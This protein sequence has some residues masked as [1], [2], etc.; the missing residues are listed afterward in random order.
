LSDG[1]TEIQSDG[2]SLTMIRLVLPVT[3][4]DDL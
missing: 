1:E 2:K 3:N 4:A